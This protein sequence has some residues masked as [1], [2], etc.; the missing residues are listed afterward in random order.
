MSTE[1]RPNEWAE[2]AL[3]TVLQA[4]RDT[5]RVV[6]GGITPLGST[7]SD[8]PA[9]DTTCN[10]AATGLLHL[11]AR[12]NSVNQDDDGE[13]TGAANLMHTWSVRA[14]MNWAQRHPE[15]A[16]GIEEAVQL[17]AKSCGDDEADF[18]SR[19][20]QENTVAVGEAI[21]AWNEHETVPAA[22]NLTTATRLTIGELNRLAQKYLTTAARNE[23]MDE[24]FIYDRDDHHE[25][26]ITY[27]YT[28]ALL[29]ATDPAGSRKDGEAPSP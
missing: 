6:D 10:Q 15:E 12:E 16:R 17:R 18:T 27:C 22:S 19:T 5:E 1:T 28:R 3:R 23:Q 11:I 13:L 9:L 4:A 25:A 29:E 21:R 20:R 14:L 8:L 24:D 7:P 2:A 26:F